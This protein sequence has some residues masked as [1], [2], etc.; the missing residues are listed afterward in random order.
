MILKGNNENQWDLTPL[1]DKMNK[2]MNKKLIFPEFLEIS[3]L[4]PFL[5]LYYPADDWGNE[6]L[7]N[8]DNFMALCNAMDVKMDAGKLKAIFLKTKS[9]QGDI[10]VYYAKGTKDVF[11]TFDFAKDPTDQ[12]GTFVLGL[13]IKHEN[14]EEIKKLI[15]PIYFKST[16]RSAYQ[17]DYFNKQLQKLV[18]EDLHWNKRILHK[19]DS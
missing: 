9:G 10:Y 8:I 2:A 5:E 7:K 13:R 11:M 12:M 14:L 6:T 19:F 16:T 1:I 3:F 18:N 4:M 15:H 17:E